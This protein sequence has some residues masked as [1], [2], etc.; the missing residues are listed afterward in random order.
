MTARLVGW[1]YRQE[2]LDR[3]APDDFGYGPLVKVERDQLRHLNVLFSLDA[4]DVER[5]ARRRHGH[6]RQQG[7]AVSVVDQSVPAYELDIEGC[8][9]EMAARRYVGLPPTLDL[10]DGGDPGYDFISPRG[11]R[12]EVKSTNKHHGRL[13]FRTRE[14]LAHADVAVL[15][16]V[17]GARSQQVGDGWLV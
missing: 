9:G 10:Y 13:F 5:E 3:C 12:V 8:A 6:K 15:V 11:N 4:A 14:Q 7:I 16:I 1:L 17:T 2:F